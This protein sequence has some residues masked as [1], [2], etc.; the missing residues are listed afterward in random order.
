MESV[1]NP[2]TG[3]GI[4]RFIRVVFRSLGSETIILRFSQYVNKLKD[5][6]F[7]RAWNKNIWNFNT[8]QLLPSNGLLGNNT[9]LNNNT[10]NNKLI[11]RDFHP[12][13]I[14]DKR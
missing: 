4:F 12:R 3:N 2:P 8:G 7:V 14:G 1:C 13:V 5:H 10:N 6:G 11:G 9:C